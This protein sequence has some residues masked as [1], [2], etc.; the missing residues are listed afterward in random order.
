MPCRRPLAIRIIS[1]AP[2]RPEFKQTDT[3]GPNR[4]HWFRA[5]FGG[6]RFRL[7]FRYDSR[8]KVIIHAWVNDRDTLRT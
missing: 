8:L 6:Q 3:L 2:S 5:K 1:I 7:F 4:K